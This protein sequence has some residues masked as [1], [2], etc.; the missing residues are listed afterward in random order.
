MGVEVGLGEAQSPPVGISGVDIDLI[1]TV[2]LNE[3]N[4]GFPGRPPSAY[5]AHK[6]GVEKLPQEPFL[7]CLT[8]THSYLHV[9]STPIGSSVHPG[10]QCSFK[11]SDSGVSGASLVIVNL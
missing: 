1:N 8:L 7:K 3:D 11:S 6:A 5:I 10:G 9:G 2:D 4:P